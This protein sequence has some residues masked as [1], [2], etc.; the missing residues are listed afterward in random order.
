MAAQ[1]PPAAAALDLAGLEGALA[2]N[3]RIRKSTELPL[4]YAQKEKDV[5]TAELF[6]E[7]FE[8]AAQIARWILPEGEPNRYQRTCREFYLLL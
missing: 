6:M 5:C 3:E 8:V 4:F 2:N 7:R 1:D